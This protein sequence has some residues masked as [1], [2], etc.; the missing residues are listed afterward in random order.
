M[1][2]TKMILKGVGIAAGVAFSCKVLKDYCEEYEKK[3]KF[4]M[5][6]YS[7]LFD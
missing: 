2:I 6:I 5:A 1:E 4:K 7:W 3:H